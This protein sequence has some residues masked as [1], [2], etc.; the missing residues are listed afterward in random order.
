MARALHKCKLP[1]NLLGT[2]AIVGDYVLKVQTRLRKT[3][4]GQADQPCF[5]GVIASPDS[6]TGMSKTMIRQSNGDLETVPTTSIELRARRRSRRVR[7]GGLVRPA[8]HAAALALADGE[9]GARLAGASVVTDVLERALLQR[10]EVARL[11]IE[12]LERQVGESRHVDAGALVGVE[13]RVHGVADRRELRLALRNELGELGVKR[14]PARVLVD[15]TVLGNEGDGESGHVR[16]LF[17]F[18]LSLL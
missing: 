14:R 13:H 6:S 10:A 9:H 2:Y 4:S 12:P 11:R 18:R 7:L 3:L 15:V 5:Y 1:R 8:L 17:C 16:L